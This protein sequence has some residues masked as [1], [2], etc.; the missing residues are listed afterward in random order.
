VPSDDLLRR[1]LLAKRKRERSVNQVDAQAVDTAQAAADR[2]RAQFY[3]KQRAF[4][5]SK[6]K[7]KA[8][9]KTRRAGAT[10]GGCS[11]LLARAITLEGHRAEQGFR[12]SI[13]HSTRVEAKARAWKNDTKSGIVD[14]LVQHG[15]R[16]ESRTLETYELGGIE[17]EVRE[18]ELALNFS[19][20]SQISLFGC[21]SESDLGKL[22]SNAKHVVW[23]DE[24]QDPRW[25]ALLA[26]LYK[27]TITGMA[28]YQVETW[29][30]GTP[31]KDPAGMFFD[32][33]RDDAPGLPGWEIHVLSVVDNPY[34]GE[35]PEERWAATAEKALI[36]NGW[37]VDD[38]DFQREWMA[39]WVM[40]DARYVYAANAVPIHELLYAEERFLPDGFPDLIAAMNDLPGR[41]DGREYFLVMGNDLGVYAF[42]VHAWSLQ[43]AV[44]YEVASF[45]KRGWD[46][47]EMFGCIKRVR[48]T[49]NIG[50]LVADAGGGGKQAVMN[51]S[52]K[53]V[54]R[55]GEPIIEAKK[56]N[57]HTAQDLYN[58]DIRRGLMK[59]RGT[60]EKPSPLLQELLTH[61]WA[62]LKSSDGKLVES[63]QT[64][65]HAC[66]SS[67]YAHRESYH[68]RFREPPPPP[69][70]RGTRE[71]MQ[72]EEREIEEEMDEQHYH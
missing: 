30:T 7:R 9:K 6:H 45:K 29:I 61:R 58:N 2:L 25:V 69:P 34:F 13:G 44:L 67:L 39:K 16:I 52:R 62:P 54:D 48:T 24:A 35:T 41:R 32:I 15:K 51:W 28:D 19:N 17:V 71:A 8:T 27:G 20:G 11:E 47:D 26:S 46:Y 64:E 18:Q 53:L 63:T 65:N 12:A 49:L 4:Y 10:T 59:Y 56:T 14:V 1:A 40:T 70:V 50:L 55:Y 72:Q 57:K 21:D 42:S 36:D 23:I 31:G 22:R 33:T 60:A 66:D 43:D 5:R 68:H 38:P 3:D 37:T